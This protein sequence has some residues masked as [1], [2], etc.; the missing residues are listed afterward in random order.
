M[1]ILLL[2]NA[3]IEGGAGLAFLFW[4]GLDQYIPGL[5]PDAGSALLIKMYGVS[6]LCLGIFSL[7]LWSRT[8]ALELLLPGLGIFALFHAGL[9]AVLL[10]YSPDPRPAVLH[11]ALALGFLTAYFRMRVSG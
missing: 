1:K 3:L 7:V 10:L 8:Y 4:P 6:A 2:L 9:T 5:E 11:G